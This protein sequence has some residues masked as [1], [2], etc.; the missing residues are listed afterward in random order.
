MTL[1]DTLTAERDALEGLLADAALDHAW[2]LQQGRLD[3]RREILALWAACQAR[4]HEERLKA[5]DRRDW[6]VAALEEYLECRAAVM[7]DLIKARGEPPEPLPMGRLRLENVRLREA[8]AGVLGALDAP[9]QVN[10][11]LLREAVKVAR[12]VLAS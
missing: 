11:P 9:P 1:I 4:H 7:V 2:W 12:D 6:N 5:G 3:E 8:L 10:V